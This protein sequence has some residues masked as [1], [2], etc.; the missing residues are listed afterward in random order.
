[1]SVPRTGAGCTKMCGQSSTR[2]QGLRGCI[3]HRRR[4]SRSQTWGTLS[5]RS[6]HFHNVPPAT[7][8]GR[9]P[10]R[11]ARR[12]SFPASWHR[13]PVA[14]SLPP[15]LGYTVGSAIILPGNRVDGAATFNGPRGFHPR[16]AYRFD[17]T[18]E[19]IRRHYR[20]E[21]SLLTAVL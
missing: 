1:M 11:G 9:A 14:P 16:I 6:V 18:L 17:L 5:A 20:G 3:W 8:D 21:A 15:D 13:C 12:W 19:C 7:A 4:D 2:R 10:V